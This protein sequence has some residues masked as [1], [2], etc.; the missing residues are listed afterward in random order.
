MLIF[1]YVFIADNVGERS[2]TRVP[3]PVCL[4]KF[5]MN[6]KSILNFSNLVKSYD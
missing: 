2:A 6:G 5:C 4:H 3:A 1:M